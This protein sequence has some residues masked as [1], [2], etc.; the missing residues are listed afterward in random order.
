M[1]QKFFLL[2]FLTLQDGTG[3]LSRNVGTELPLD[4]ASNPRKGQILR[5]D[6]NELKIEI[7]QNA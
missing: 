7:G 5:T 6:V 3:R 2:E 4:D 1:G